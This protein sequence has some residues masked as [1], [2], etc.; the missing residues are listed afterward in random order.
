MSVQLDCVRYLRL[1]SLVLTD[2]LIPALIALLGVMPNLSCLSIKSM[3]TTR[4]EE[5]NVS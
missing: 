4:C 2:D 3:R 5:S 1:T